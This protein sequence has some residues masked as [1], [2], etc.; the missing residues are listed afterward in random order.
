MHRSL[1]LVLS[2]LLS[3]VPALTSAAELTP[4]EKAFFEQHVADVIRLDAQRLDAPAV[5]KVF[6]SPMYLVK[7]MR[8]EGEGDELREIAVARLGDKLASLSV[9]GT[10]TDLPGFVKMLNP[11]FRLRT[12]ADATTLQ[13]ALDAIFPI[14]TDSD[15]K[16]KGFRRAGNQWSFMRGEFFEDKLGFLF[17]TDASGAI[18][19]VKYQL[20]LP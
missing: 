6:S 11:A 19:S 2:T 12:N 1:A 14:V 10:D 8:L 3:A 7:V 20:R 5:A 9:P 17:E 15:R 18:K 4:A 13:Q 16:M